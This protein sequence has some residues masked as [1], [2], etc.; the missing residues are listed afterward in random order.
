MSD[1]HFHG[2]R[3]DKEEVRR[4]GREGEDH[5]FR[6]FLLQLLIVMIMLMTTGAAPDSSMENDPAGGTR[7]ICA[8][9][10]LAKTAQPMAILSLPENTVPRPSPNMRIV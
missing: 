1:I 5:F 4:E 8:R 2:R 9:Q 7:G 10:A 3:N 6:S